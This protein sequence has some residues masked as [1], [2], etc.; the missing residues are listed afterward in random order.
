MCVQYIE[1]SDLEEST[2]QSD[3]VRYNEAWQQ[4][5]SSGGVLIP[6]GF[7]LRGIEGKILA[8]QWARTNKRPYLGMFC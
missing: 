8:A 5:R 1:A 7:G 6:G 4:L 2:R 3:P